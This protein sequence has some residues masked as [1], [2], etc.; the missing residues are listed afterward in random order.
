M[1]QELDIAT[2]PIVSSCSLYELHDSLGY[3]AMGINCILGVATL[4]LGL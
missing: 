2:G 1:L 3:T 4:A